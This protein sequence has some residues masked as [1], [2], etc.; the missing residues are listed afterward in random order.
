MLS[1]VVVYIYIGLCICEE[2]ST[3]PVKTGENVSGR[4]ET[5]GIEVVWYR[6]LECVRDMFN[7]LYLSPKLFYTKGILSKLLCDR[8]DSR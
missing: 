1:E 8:R 2:S 6:S 4:E 3:P 5:L 7:F